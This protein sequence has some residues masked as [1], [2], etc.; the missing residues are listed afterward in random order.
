MK[1]RVEREILDDL[2][3]DHPQAKRSRRDLILINRL[4][5]HASLL[6]KPLERH[7]PFNRPI[8]LLEMGSGDGTLSARLLERLGNVCAG[9]RIQLVDQLPILSEASRRMLEARGWIVEESVS[10]IF[11]WL[12]NNETRFDGC[13][14][15]LFIHHFETRAL[16]ILFE[17]LSKHVDLFMC[18][19]PRRDA[20]AAW[21]AAGL[22]LL[23]C[24]KVTLNDAKLSVSAGFNDDELTQIWNSVTD[25]P[26]WHL[27]EQ[28]ARGFSHF[29]IARNTGTD[30][31]E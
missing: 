13:F 11:E 31:D 20:I 19:E 4:M 22:R 3:V 5:G 30:A 6:S 28:R 14:A 16:K 24:N 12:S 15:N 29:F 23:G 1:R 7:L 9:S 21:G 2:P 8:H 25:S 17:H 18:T 26:S 10:D 27:S